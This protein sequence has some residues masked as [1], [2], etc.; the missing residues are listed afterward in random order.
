MKRINRRRKLFPFY[1]GWA[2]VAAAFME[3]IVSMGVYNN[4]GIFFKPI[5]ADFGWNR[6]QTAGAFSA[7]GLL[8][9]GLSPFW[10]A[11]ADKYGPRLFIMV[12][13]ISLAAGYILISQMNSLW[14]FYLFFVLFIGIGQSVS[15]TTILS[16]LPRWFEAKRGM[17]QGI[18]QSGAGLGIGLAPL[19][20]T[21]LILNHNWRLAFLVSG[22]M[23]GGIV[24]MVAWIFRRSPQDMG[25]LP[26]GKPVS[27]DDTKRGSESSSKSNKAS[28]NSSKTFTFR[29]ALSTHNLRKLLF[30]TMAA[31]FAHILIV[32]HLVPYATDI[33]FSPTVAAT[34]MVVIGLAN[35]L[36]KI[37]LGLASDRVGRRAALAFCFGLAAIMF[38]LLM[39]TKGL[40]ALYIFAAGFGFAYGGWLPLFPAIS[41][42]LFGVR[43]LGAIYGLTNASSAVGGALGGFMGGYIFDSTQSY[44]YAFLI[45]EM[46]LLVA[47]ALLLSLKIQGKDNHDVGSHI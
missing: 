46:L 7:A 18:V 15:T 45:S 32:T 40:W 11:Q 19:L 6:A 36:S 3:R 41:A 17:V 35:A 22:L 5:M 43:S 37:I 25:I 30:V 4:M 10:G 1:Y 9:G 13:A 14:Q 24:F 34:F 47:F 16:T 26:D 8:T 33:G 2:I 44:S 39:T 28:A 42:D 27:L 38:V 23:I 12:E 31:G 20:L 21:Y 29:E